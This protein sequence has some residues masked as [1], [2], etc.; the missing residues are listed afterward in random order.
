MMAVEFPSGTVTFLFTD[1]EGSTRLLKSLGPRYDEVLADHQRI[2]RRAFE[3]HG[4]REVDTQGDSFFVAFARAKDAVAAAVAAQRELAGHHWPEGGELKVRMGLH[5]GEPRVGD[6]R[7]VGIGV[8][9]AARIGAA[10]HGGQVLLSRTSRELVEDELPPGVAIRDLGQRRLKDLDARERLSQLVIAGL[11]N[12]FGR[13]RTVDEELGRRRRLMYVGSALIGVV[14]AAV[15]IPIFALA[16]EGSATGVKVAPNS[17]AV[18]DAHSDRIVG[19][20][21]VG[22]RPQAVA[23]GVGSIWVANQDDRT[24]S[25]INPQTTAVER[26][27]SLPSTP[28]DLAVGYGAVWVVNGTAGS[29]SRVDPGTDQVLATKHLAQEASVGSDAIGAGSIWV[30]FDT[31]VVARLNPTSGTVVTGLAGTG[32]S[33]V[34]Y[35]GGAVWVANSGDNTVSRILP[36]TATEVGTVTVGRHPSGIAVGDGAVWVTDELDNTVSRIDLRSNSQYSIPVGHSPTGIAVAGGYVWVANS[37]EGT[38]AKIDAAQ[39]RVVATI[40]TGNRPVGVA[41]A[42]GRVWVSIQAAT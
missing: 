7:Y 9:K 35:G 17:V 29:V 8:H 20:V 27:I 36:A 26:T 28:T 39:R 22:V 32:P 18:L 10:G 30:A 40:P 11:Q 2:L 21:A 37:G 5:T 4:G 19:S 24:L 15:A 25:R 34:A 3:A 1:V 13:L 23:A 6:E 41:A 42:R 31:A 12:D 33:G 38:I 16:Q 14:A